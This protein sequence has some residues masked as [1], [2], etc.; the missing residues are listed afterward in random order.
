M[1]PD[2]LLDIPRI[3][4]DGPFELDRGQFTTRRQRIDPG[5]GQ[6]PPQP[7]LRSRKEPIPYL[8]DL[9]L[10]LHSPHPLSY[11]LPLLLLYTKI[12]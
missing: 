12:I 2:E 7:Y 1:I 4:T 8:H 5:P 11:G 9:G 6:V 10:P 3:E